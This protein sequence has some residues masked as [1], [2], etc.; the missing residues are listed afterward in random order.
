MAQRKA[1]GSDWFAK[2]ILWVESNERGVA[3][4]RQ[5]TATRKF[6]SYHMIHGMVW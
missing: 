4:N 5:E 2:I 6:S 1:G 3:D